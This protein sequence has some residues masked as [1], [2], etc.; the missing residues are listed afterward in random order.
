VPNVTITI[1]MPEKMKAFVDQRLASGQFGNMSEYF[2][3]LVRMDNEH[4]VNERLKVL[5]EEGEKSGVAELADNSWFA[6]L[7][8]EVSDRAHRDKSA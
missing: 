8:A 5:L 2:R 3:H 4:A 6:K 1:S 7:R